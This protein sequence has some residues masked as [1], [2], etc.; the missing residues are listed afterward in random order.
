M[1]SRASG[2]RSSAPDPAGSSWCPIAAQ[3]AASLTVYQRSANWCTPLNNT[4][5][6]PEEQ[7]QLRAE[8]ESIRET[9]N[10]SPAGFLHVAHDRA[11][12]E[13]SEDERLA[14]YEKMW[15]S[16]GFSKLT[17]NYTDLLF[18][19]AANA[20][21]TE[22]IA[23]KI[24]G[25]VHDPQTADKLDPQ[26]PVRRAPAAVRDRLFRDVQ[27]AKRLARRSDR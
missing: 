6:T 19:E 17:S 2:S 8:F 21:W 11:T 22:F 4:P 20:Q 14:F 23:G 3:E 16:P 15:R 7:A 26:A 18:D 10:T 27:P 1:T 13:D 12:F 24:R 9:L 25:I 5:I